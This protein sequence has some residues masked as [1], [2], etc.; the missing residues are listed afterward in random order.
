MTKRVFR[1]NYLTLFINEQNDTDFLYSEF[2][3]GKN[4]TITLQDATVTA[5]PPQSMRVTSGE[6]LKS[7]REL[8]IEHNGQEYRLLKTSNNKLLLVK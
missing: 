3:M 8:V 4:E 7:G 5:F 1:V 2:Y 6:L